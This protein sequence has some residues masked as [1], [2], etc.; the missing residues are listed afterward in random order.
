MQIYLLRHE[1]YS[2]IGRNKVTKSLPQVPP[3]L[4]TDTFQ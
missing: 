3:A 2:E 4:P 1:I